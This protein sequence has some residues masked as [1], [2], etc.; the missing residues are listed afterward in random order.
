M[1][2][3]TRKILTRTLYLSLL[4]SVLP[5]CPGGSGTNTLT[6][7]KLNPTEVTEVSCPKHYKKLRSD[8]PRRTYTTLLLLVLTTAT[9]LT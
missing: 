7:F 3:G 6:Y 1:E 2:Q 4:R 8:T 9:T 5:P